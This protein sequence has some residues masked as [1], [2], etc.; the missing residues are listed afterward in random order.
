MTADYHYSIGP[1]SAFVRVSVSRQIRFVSL[2]WVRAGRMF[3]LFAE[4]RMS[5][6]LCVIYRECFG[7]LFIICLTVFIRKSMHKRQA[8]SQIQ[9]DLVCIN[10]KE[11]KDICYT[12]WHYNF[13]HPNRLTPIVCMCVWH[14]RKQISTYGL[15]QSHWMPY[16]TRHVPKPNERNGRNEIGR[17]TPMWLCVCARLDTSSTRGMCQQRQCRYPLQLILN[18]FRV[19]EVDLSINLCERTSDIRKNSVYCVRLCVCV[20]DIDC[21]FAIEDGVQM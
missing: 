21:D 4:H 1:L 7:S 3:F 8:F 6:Y 16:R 12:L 17:K 11:K 15:I 9:I 13:V 20:C 18:R 2:E 5:L 10:V 19:Y 14:C